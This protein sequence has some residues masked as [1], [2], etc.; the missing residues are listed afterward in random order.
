V[1]PFYRDLVLLNEGAIVRDQDKHALAY[2]VLEGPLGQAIGQ[3]LGWKVTEDVRCLSCHANRRADVPAAADAAL[4][5]RE[6]VGCEACHGPGSLYEVVHQQPSWRTKTPKEKSDLGMVDVRN[7]LDRVRQCASCHVGNWQEGKVV[8][9]EM[10]AAGHP[11]LPPFE[12]AAF[13]EQMP[14]HWRYLCEKGALYYETEFLKANGYSD[15]SAARQILPVLREVLLGDVV[16]AVTALRLE[17]QWAANAAPT[18]FDLAAFDCQACHHDL[19]QPSWRQER[20][21]GASPPGRPTAPVAAL[22]IIPAVIA[23][24]DMPAEDKAPY[25]TQ[26]QTLLAKR[27]AAFTRQPF[28]DPKAIGEVS[29]ELV[30]WLE[31]ELLPKCKQAAFDGPQARRFLKALLHEQQKTFDYGSARLLGWA[32][33]ALCGELAV[34][35]PEAFRKVEPLPTDEAARQAQVE[36]DLALWQQWLAGAQMHRQQLRQQTFGKSGLEAAL[37]LQLPAGQKVAI[38]DQMPSLLSAMAAY[39]PAAVRDH[40]AHLGQLLMEIGTMPKE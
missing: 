15:S 9:H 18:G 28:G 11:V 29:N 24:L 6:G 3:R 31:S 1:R 12:A 10:Y 23:A 25:I 30:E 20:G 2:K 4:V 21:Y 40:T 26:W 27:H 13:A 36:A 19:K 5:V 14:R 7:P 32:A 35:Y 16:A 22:A 34:D 39:N 8:T 33:W 37:A 38:T 17:S